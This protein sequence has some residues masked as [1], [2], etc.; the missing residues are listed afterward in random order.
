MGLIQSFW[1]QS[2]SPDELFTVTETSRALGVGR[3]KLHELGIPT[4]MVAGQKCY[5]KGDVVAYLALPQNVCRYVEMRHTQATNWRRRHGAQLREAR[6]RLDQ[7]LYGP[8]E[9][10]MGPGWEA[11]EAAAYEEANGE[12]V[13][14]KTSQPNLTQEQEDALWDAAWKRHFRAEVERM[15]LL[16]GSGRRGSK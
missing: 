8:S 12:I 7:R 5:R 15:G 13:S 6:Q 4:R 16:S 10:G 3:N 14:A 9:P 1:L 11:A 2:T